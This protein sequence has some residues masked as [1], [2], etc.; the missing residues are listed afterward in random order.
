[1]RFIGYTSIVLAL[2]LP[3]CYGPADYLTAPR[4]ALVYGSGERPV[5]P[6][7]LRVNPKD[8]PQFRAK[9]QVKPPP[10]KLRIDM[11]EIVPGDIW[12]VSYRVR[13]FYLI[14]SNTYED[15][16]CRSLNAAG[17]KSIALLSRFTGK[18]TN[19]Y[20]YG[21]YV[22]LT[23]KVTG[24]WEILPNSSRIILSSERRQYLTPDPISALS[25]GVQPLFTKAK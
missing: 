3:G 4:E 25:W 17:H 18:C 11:V 15:R 22:D 7:Q 19:Q 16:L 10:T 23:G 9:Q 1:M 12:Q 24:G 21:I 6:E 20:I 8:F 14:T 2:M 13:D 5:D